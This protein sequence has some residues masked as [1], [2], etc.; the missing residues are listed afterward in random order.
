[1]P[2]ELSPGNQKIQ[3]LTAPNF[4]PSLSFLQ[5]NGTLARRDF[6]IT[7][8]AFPLALGIALEAPLCSI[9]ES[10][11]KVPRNKLIRCSTRMTVPSEN[12]PHEEESS[13]E[14]MGGDSPGM[15]PPLYEDLR[16]LAIW[17]MAGE[18][19][20]QT[21]SATALVHEAYLKIAKSQEDASWQSRGHFYSA[22]AE[23]MRRILIDRARRKK[24]VR[25]GGQWERTEFDTIKAPGTEPDK[26]EELLALDEA[27][28]E[29]A[30]EDLRK[31]KLVELRYFVGLSV[32]EAAEILEISTATAKRDW[33]FARAWLH[34][35]IS[36]KIG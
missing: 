20:G 8:P 32:E 16:K 3:F 27:L 1:M 6:L 22:I 28:S 13:G 34:H 18:A 19:P 23:E 26:P 31:A 14:E 7:K 2:R 12:P 24:A 10:V 30:K 5:I 4:S 36:G 11:A 35:S 25:H 9:P 21:I 17:K 15:L 29:L 33:A